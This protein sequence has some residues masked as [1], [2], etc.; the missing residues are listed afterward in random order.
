MSW[1]TLPDFTRKVRR[2][3]AWMIVASR[4]SATIV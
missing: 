1:P 2:V 3:I 4:T